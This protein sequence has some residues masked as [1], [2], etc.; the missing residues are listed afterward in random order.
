M[1]N[2]EEYLSISDAYDAINKIFDR[3]DFPDYS[4]K[5][6]HIRKIYDLEVL[7]D[8]KVRFKLDRHPHAFGFASLGMP[9]SAYRTITILYELD[10]EKN[11]IVEI[12][13]DASELSINYEWLADDE[14]QKVFSSDYDNFDLS[15]WE[16]DLEKIDNE[17]K[18]KQYAIRAFEEYYI[19]DKDEFW[20]IIRYDQED[21]P[22][23]F[24]LRLLE[25]IKKQFVPEMIELWEG[26][27]KPYL[28]LVKG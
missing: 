6:K 12:G 15:K 3:G 19:K 1:K 9:S 11:E 25:E 27:K 24:K 23:D 4:V 20:F 14:V 16:T 26:A 17:E 5:L 21:L 2:N 22:E 18:A 7:S 28:K 13:R 10:T 8:N